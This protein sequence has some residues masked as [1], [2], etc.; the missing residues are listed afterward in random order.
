M[1]RQVELTL[2][3][4]PGGAFSAV[5]AVESRAQLQFGREIRCIALLARGRALRHAHFARLA[6]KCR[7]H[8]IR[9]AAAQHPREPGPQVARL[10]RGPQPSEPRIL[11][12]VLG[13]DGPPRDAARQRAHPAL[14]DQ[15]LL[16]FQRRHLGLRVEAL[17]RPTCSHAGSSGCAAK[18]ARAR[19]LSPP[20]GQAP[21][22]TSN[23][24][25]ARSRR[26][27]GPPR[28][29]R[30]AAGLRRGRW[31]VH[32]AHRAPAARRARRAHRSLA[33]TTRCAPACRSN[34][35]ARQRGISNAVTRA[36]ERSHAPSSTSRARFRSTSRC[37]ASRPSRSSA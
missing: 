17:A 21:T 26:L 11:S 18:L 29:A 2:Q 31:F 3:A 33:S 16:Q 8:C 23:F 36:H 30:F 6:S 34:A 37:T 27:D 1:R 12:Q 4:D 24:G 15:Q 28:N 9:R 5:V 25:L 7:A 22:R 14:V 19:S 13:V 35:S 10:R 20:S 32:A